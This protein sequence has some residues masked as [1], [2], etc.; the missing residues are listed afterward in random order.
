[1]QEK[2]LKSTRLYEGKIINLR[3]DTV[4]LPDKK[5]SKREIVE[6]SGAAAVVPM[7]MNGDVILV[8][9][10]RK[11]VEEII[12]EIPAG[13]LEPKESAEKCALRELAE[14]TGYTV[15]SLEKLAS[16]YT[17]PGF[18]DEIIHVY[19][20]RDLTEGDARPDEDEYLEVVRLPL[21]E[22]LEMISRGDIKD[23]KT[24]IGL[25]MAARARQ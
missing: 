8:K 11:P 24:M 1:M 21:E 9:Q 23:S 4:E 17:S 16:F 25:L 19:L 6:H 20:A 5:Y 7:T 22:A 13:R 14:E 3:V 10:F 18:S 2:T 12:Y 15:G